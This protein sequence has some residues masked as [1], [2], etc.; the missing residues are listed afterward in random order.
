[1]SNGFYK[2][3]VPLETLPVIHDLAHHSP[4]LGVPAQMM[5]LFSSPFV[6]PP[7]VDEQLT[8]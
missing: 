6:L 2:V 8:V 3:V 5:E 4:Q 1:M 7:L